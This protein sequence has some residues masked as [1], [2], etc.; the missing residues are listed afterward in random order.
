MKNPKEKAGILSRLT[1][2]WMGSVLK[3]GY[4][5]AMECSDLY[6]LLEEDKARTLTEHLDDLWHKEVREFHISGKQPSLLRAMRKVF[7][8][9]EYTLLSIALFLGIACNILKPLLLGLLISMLLSV[10]KST[11]DEE[12]QWLYTYAGTICV[13]ALLQVLALHQY[14]YKV[15]ILGMRW[16][17]AVVGLLYK[18]VCHVI[19]GVFLISYGIVW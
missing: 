8:W 7:S 14:Q 2:C 3:I 13:A 5:R 4:R 15:H 17:A 10:G 6:P 18:K 9:T 1:F 11:S 16:R 19:V 12:L